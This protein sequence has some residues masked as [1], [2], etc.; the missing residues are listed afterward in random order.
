MLK[1]GFCVSH[2]SFWVGTYKPEFSRSCELLI[3]LTLTSAIPQCKVWH[4][5][6]PVGALICQ[7]GGT[8]YSVQSSM[9][10]WNDLIGHEKAAF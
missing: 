10:L 8:G 1:S 5:Q 6:K 3:I 4:R 7:H 2:T 9:F